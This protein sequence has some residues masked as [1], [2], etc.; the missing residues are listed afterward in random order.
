[1]RR[2]G[3]LP[4]KI[5]AQ[6]VVINDDQGTNEMFK[7]GPKGDISPVPFAVNK[8]D[9]EMRPQEANTTQSLSRPRYQVIGVWNEA[10]LQE[11]MGN[12]ETAATAQLPDID[13]LLNR[14]TQK[15]QREPL[16]SIYT[17]FPDDFRFDCGVNS[18]LN[19][20]NNVIYA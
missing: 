11:V 2:S 13:S 6:Y 7:I 12:Q 18:I 5:P 4:A 8:Q 20:G 9:A 1:M 19:L 14:K 16:P 17:L 15:V 10:F 3:R